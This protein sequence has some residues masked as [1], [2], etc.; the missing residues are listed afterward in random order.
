MTRE[1]KF[2]EVDLSI[3]LVDTM[4]KGHPIVQQ[5]DFDKEGNVVGFVDVKLWEV[6][7]AILNSVTNGIGIRKLRRWIVELPVAGKM[8]ITKGDYTILEKAIENFDNTDTIKI[9]SATR[10]QLLEVLDEAVKD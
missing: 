4:K 5:P 2:Y 3:P 9:P 10:G 7:N 1:E 6:M 8:T